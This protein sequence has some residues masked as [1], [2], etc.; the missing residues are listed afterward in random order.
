MQFSVFDL[1]VITT[2]ASC[3]LAAFFGAPLYW[4][5]DGAHGK[6]GVAAVEL[7]LL[8]CLFVFLNLRN[9]LQLNR[10]HAG[11]L[12]EQ[13]DHYNE[14]EQTWADVL[15]PWLTGSVFVFF[16]IWLLLCE[17]YQQAIPWN[18]WLGLLPS[19]AL[20]FSFIPVWKRFGPSNNVV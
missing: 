13:P 9:R 19:T 20:A 16:G 6:F 1:L 2:Y 14:T 18:W 8:L 4:E 11:T 12:V 3:S 5:G 7:G 17:F 15:L 10:Q